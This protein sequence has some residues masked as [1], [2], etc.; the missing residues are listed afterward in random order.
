MHDAAQ[1]GDLALLRDL[2][3]A[4]PEQINALDQGD[5]PRAPLHHAVRQFQYRSVQ[6]LLEHGADA[7]VRDG[8]GRTAL[9]LAATLKYAAVFPLLFKHKADVN[10]KDDFSS[11]PLCEAV[12]S[13]DLEGVRAL[14]ARK[15]DPNIA[16]RTGQ[17]PLHE[18]AV[19]GHEEI[20]AVLL[21]HKADLNAGGILAG[22][23][24]ESATRY[25]RIMDR[26]IAK[27][28][29]VN[30]Q[31]AAGRTA[32]HVAT[33]NGRPEAVALLLKRK[34]DVE[35]KDNDGLTPLMW[36]VKERRTEIA[37]LLRRAGA[38]D[39][40]PKDLALAGSIHE[41]AGTGNLRKVKLQIAADPKKVDARSP[42]TGGTPLHDAASGGRTAVVQF[43][44]EKNA[45]IDAR[46][47]GGGT[48]LHE[49]ARAGRRGAAV[50][51]LL[52][53][54]GADANA[55]DAAGH[56]PLHNAVVINATETVRT[57]LAHKADPSIRAKDG[58]LPEDFAAGTARGQIRELLREARQAR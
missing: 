54:R 28:A 44:L 23:P 24:L 48:P 30:K 7:N 45:Q 58:K 13:G 41:A 3:R 5:P 17:T 10:A 18:A 36:A 14:L 38:I 50:A 12:I 15:A 2:L 19:R 27:G 11:T 46:D 33:F 43:L 56:T 1:R 8:R 34:A 29:D 16:Q 52:L 21:Q 40:T 42:S 31:D 55:Q 6:F 47:S 9:H 39:P 35:I 20:A 25:P 32:L 37:N 57:L 49:A 22:P 4:H 51:A 26:M 53:E